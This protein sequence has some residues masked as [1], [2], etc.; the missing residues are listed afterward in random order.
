MTIFKFITEI[1]NAVREVIPGDFNVKIAVMNDSE[2]FGF[3]VAI[4]YTDPGCILEGKRIQV[5]YLNVILDSDLSFRVCDNSIYPSFD[6]DEKR[7]ELSEFI[8]VLKNELSHDRAQI[9]FN[10]IIGK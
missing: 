10:S 8:D 3:D 6:S 7:Y 5:A 1:E 9:L 4:E 2:I